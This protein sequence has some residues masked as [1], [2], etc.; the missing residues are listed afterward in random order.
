MFISKHAIRSVSKYS[1][2]FISKTKK[3]KTLLCRVF[4][5]FFFFIFRFFRKLLFPHCFEVTDLN[6]WLAGSCWAE[7]PCTQRADYRWL[8][9]SWSWW[10]P[11]ERSAWFAT[12]KAFM[13]QTRQ[14]FLENM[15]CSITKL[16]SLIL[17]TPVFPFQSIL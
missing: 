13:S 3:K 11:V 7:R 14:L 10:F 1:T 8:V 4:F 5:F 17:A 9:F 12:D 2:V 6:F 15:L 16:I